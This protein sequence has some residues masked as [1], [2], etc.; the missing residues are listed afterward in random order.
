M[1]VLRTLIEKYTK[2]YKG[3]LYTCFIDFWKAFERAEHNILFYNL[4]QIGISG[5]FYNIIKDTYANNSLSVKI[6]SDFTQSFPS[7][8]GDRQG[9]TLSPDLF[10]VFI[11]DLPEIFDSSCDGFDIG[12]YHLNCLS[13]A[14]GVI[15]LSKTETGLQNCISKLGK[16]CDDWCL[17]VNYDKSKVIVFNKAGK[18]YE[19]KFTYKDQ[20]LE[21][22]REYRYLGVTFAIS[23]SFS[24]ASSELYEKGLK[25]FFKLKSIFGT[26]TL[27]WPYIYLTIPLNLYLITEVKSGD[28]AQ[29]NLISR[30]GQLIQFIKI[31]MQKN[32]IENFV[33]ISLELIQRLLIWQSLV[34]WAVSP[35]IM[36]FVKI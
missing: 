29:E 7:N 12:T 34:N 28:H 17:E 10:K 18:F 2:D 13:Y 6:K 19:T 31:Y 33:S 8:I 3:K 25:G 21:S 14:G 4:R 36:I 11:N 22:V 15:L 24:Y 5:N 1:F 32:Y 20:K 23:G 30:L 35:C 27:M 16:Y 9:D 26:R